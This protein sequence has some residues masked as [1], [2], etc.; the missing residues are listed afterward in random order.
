MDSFIPR[1]VTAHKNEPDSQE[2]TNENDAEGGPPSPSSSETSSTGS[3]PRVGRSK[4]I[5]MQILGAKLLAWQNPL[6][7]SF[8]N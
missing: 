5:H 4:L 3:P 6:Y 1:P 2:E 7:F 8:F